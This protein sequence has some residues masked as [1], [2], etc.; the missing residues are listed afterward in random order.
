M[1]TYGGLSNM[2]ERCTNLTTVSG[3]VKT[4]VFT[5]AP[6]IEY[7]FKGCSKLTKIYWPF[8]THCEDFIDKFENI[9]QS[10]FS[11]W[12]E[13]TAVGTTRNILC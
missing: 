1:V 7:M 11:D 9:N 8:T 4:E 2:F 13:G 3:I 5:P 6:S 12:L 10:I